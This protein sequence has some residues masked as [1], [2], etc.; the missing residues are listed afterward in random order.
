MHSLPANL[1]KFQKVIV[2]TKKAIAIPFKGDL[3]FIILI[4]FSALIN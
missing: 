1:E 3:V 2:I 4:Y